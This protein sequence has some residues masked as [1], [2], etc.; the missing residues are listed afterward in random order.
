MKRLQETVKVL[1]KWRARIKKPSFLEE[2]WV[3]GVDGGDWTGKRTDLREGRWLRASTARQRETMTTIWRMQTNCETCS[4]PLTPISSKGTLLASV[5]GWF[6]ENLQ[7]EFD[8][9]PWKRILRSKQVSES[10]S[11][12]SFCNMCGWNV[13]AGRRCR[14]IEILKSLELAHRLNWPNRC[15]R[16]KTHG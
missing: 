9:T 10:C 6:C 8:S 12:P 7:T 11:M 1:T 13:S 16:L 5:S 3:R 4:L 14:V 2:S 15:S